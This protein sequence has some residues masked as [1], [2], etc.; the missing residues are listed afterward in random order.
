MSVPAIDGIVLVGESTHVRRDGAFG[1]RTEA[2]RDDRDR[3]LQGGV[4]VPVNVAV[5]RFV[6]RFGTRSSAVVAIVVFGGVAVAS[7]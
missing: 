6:A 7:A 1:A 5:P 3:E 2:R 4:N